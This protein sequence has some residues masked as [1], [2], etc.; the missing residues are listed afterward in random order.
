MIKNTINEKVYIGSA[1]NTDRRF[2]HHKWFLNKGIHIN[3]H[4]QSA[5][6]LYGKEAFIFFVHIECDCEDLI[7]FE[8]QT[9]DNMVQ[10]L[11]RENVYNVCLTAGSSLGRMLS[12]ETREKIGIKSRGR[13]A[14][15]KHTEET[16]T[17]ISAGNAGKN[18][19]KKHTE[20]AKLKMSVYRKGRKF[21][22]EHRA[23]LAESIRKSWERRKAI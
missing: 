21:S 18:K 10:I 16:K 11:G 6:N 13:W 22:Q 17:K 20:E 7:K 9:I 1:V 15:K 4:L 5:W 14:G 2:Y 23:N 19:G 12:P 8:Q 3:I